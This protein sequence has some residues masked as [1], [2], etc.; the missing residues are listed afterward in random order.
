MPLVILCWLALG[1]FAAPVRAGP[2]SLTCPRILVTG[3]VGSTPPSGDDP[4]GPYTLPEIAAQNERNLAVLRARYPNGRMIRRLDSGAES[5]IYEIAFSRAHNLIVKIPRRRGD[6]RVARAFR[7]ERDI[8]RRAR[9]KDSEGG[10]FLVGF[11]G[12]SYWDEIESYVLVQ[13]RAASGSLEHNLQSFGPRA[14]RDDPKRFLDYWRQMALALRAVHSIDYVHRDVKPSNF[15]LHEDRILLTDFGV[16]AREGAAGPPG[17]ENLISG[18]L[19]HM[20]ENQ[21]LRHYATR[22][23]DLHSL[24]LTYR[25]M[26]MGKTVWQVDPRVPANHVRLRNIDDFGTYPILTGLPDDVARAAHPKLVE[27]TRQSFQRIQQVLDA[28]AALK[29]DD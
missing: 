21:M 6:E 24:S 8:L 22:S 11:Y 27:L 17:L 20:S 12:L 29:L 1:G 7:A 23:D 28:L 25:E 5:V 14:S 26:L 18:T 19:S 2:A 16:S 9:I 4:T 10:R 13:Q 15:L 3:G